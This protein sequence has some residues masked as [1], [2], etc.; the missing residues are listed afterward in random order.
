MKSKRRA[1]KKQT[2]QNMPPG[3]NAPCDCGSKRKWKKCCGAPPRPD[4]YAAYEHMDEYP[5]IAGGP[6]ADDATPVDR[7]GRVTMNAHDDE[8]PESKPIPFRLS[9]Y[10]PNTHMILG[11]LLSG[12]DPL[13]MAKMLVEAQEAQEKKQEGHDDHQEN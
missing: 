7:G 2:G 4:R 9:D 11:S 13:K 5:L 10:S 1:H 3:R 8:E 6:F 12:G